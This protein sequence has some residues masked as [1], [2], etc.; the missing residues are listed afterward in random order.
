MRSA[1]QHTADAEYCEP[2]VRIGRR[3]IAEPQQRSEVLALQRNVG[4]AQINRRDGL[5]EG[6]VAVHR[7][8]LV[9]H[10]IR[11]GTRSAKPR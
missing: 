11:Q 6:V 7:Q 5:R 9:E 3:R 10:N 1:V 8:V 2:L 4:S